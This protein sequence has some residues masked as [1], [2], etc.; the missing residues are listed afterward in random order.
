[1]ESLAPHGTQMSA[2]E[3]IDHLVGVLDEL[4]FAPSAANRA[5]SNRLACGTARSSNWAE[6]R[7]CVVCS[8][9]LGLMPGAPEIWEA[10][11]AANRLED[12]K[13]VV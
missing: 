11:V 4:G 7:A 10:P 5:G 12:R 9:H 8:I 6:T 1:M 3:S 13:S 2:D